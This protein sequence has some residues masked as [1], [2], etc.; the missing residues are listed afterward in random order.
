MT[1]MSVSSR[2]TSQLRRPVRRVGL[3][4]LVALELRK[5]VDTRSGLW[6]NVSVLA[7][8]L[9]VMAVA[10]T[11]DPPLS[12]AASII[13][14]GSVAVS[15][16]LPISAILSLTSEWAQGSV[17]TTFVLVPRRFRIV[18]AKLIAV[19]VSGTLATG[20]VLVT[21]AG[22]AGVTRILRDAP[23][24]TWD[25]TVRHAALLWL[26]ILLSMGMGAAFGSVFMNPP[27][28]IV[29]YL[30]IPLLW[31]I[32]GQLVEAARDVAAW[33]DTSVTYSRLLDGSLEGAEQWQQ[34]AASSVAWVA[35]PLMLGLMR[36]ARREVS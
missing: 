15:L 25:L 31:S 33:L 6:L 24:G 30:G 5:L 28:A 16:V 35:L 21:G 8:A 19:A 27:T 13:S 4:R 12:T 34:L 20:F 14:F 11:T 29:A 26:G 18:A 7:L 36:L 32:A 17:V 3:H 10:A 2:D 23:A 9:L 1:A 22:A